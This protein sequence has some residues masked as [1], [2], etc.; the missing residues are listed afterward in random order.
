MKKMNRWHALVEIVRILATKDRP[1]LAFA[2]VCVMALP[3]ALVA[4][5]IFYTLRG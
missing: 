5:L 1:G 4:W 2:S 3:L